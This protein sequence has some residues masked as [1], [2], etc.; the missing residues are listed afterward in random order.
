M[1]NL[2]PTHHAALMLFEDLF[3]L[4]VE[5]SLQRMGIRQLVLLHK[6]LDGFGL[7]PLGWHPP[8]P[9]RYASK[10][11]GKIATSSPMMLSTN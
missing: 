6:R 9:R 3:Q 7:F 8:H 11:S 4:L 1:V 2:I 10:G 5:E